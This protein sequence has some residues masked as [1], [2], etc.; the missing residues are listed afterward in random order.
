MPKTK[1]RLT[2]EQREARRAEQRELVAASIEQLRS[3]DGWQ[4]YLH[5]RAAFRSYSP[6]GPLSNSCTFS[7]AAMIHFPT[8]SPCAYSEAPAMT[9]SA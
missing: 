9:S 6:R 3:S 7:N 1:P 8:A 2:D 5:T 4:R